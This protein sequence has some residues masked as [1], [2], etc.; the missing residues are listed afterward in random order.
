[1]RLRG[2]LSCLLCGC[3]LLALSGCGNKGPL[4]LEEDDQEKKEQRQTRVY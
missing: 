1:V 2:F 4:V 3:L